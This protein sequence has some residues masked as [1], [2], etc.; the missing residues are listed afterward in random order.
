M[1]VAKQEEQAT[2]DV[3]DTK[4]LLFQFAWWMK[5]QGYAE[6][7]ITSREKLLRILVKRGADL[8]DN[9]SI[10]AVIAKQEWSQGRK[11]NAVH[12]YSSFLKM[13][14]GTWEPPR[15]RRIPKIPWIPLENE[16]DQLIAGCSHRI[17]TFLQLLKETGMRP[18]EAWNLKLT[19]IDYEINSV[20]I[21]PEKGSNP[22]ILRLSNKLIS[23]LKKLPR[24][25]E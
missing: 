16:V 2:G 13:I 12:A 6:Q 11:Q 15:Y 1:T 24:K 9:E 18:G 3:S 21:E 14:G 7:T 10:K 19:D 8:F 22:R 4:S 17:A 20:R 23:M 5:K 25:N